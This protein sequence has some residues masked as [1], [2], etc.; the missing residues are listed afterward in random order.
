M[1]VCACGCGTLI[2]SDKR[3][4]KG[5]NR[6]L[7]G[8]EYLEQDC[9]YETPCWVWQRGLMPRGYGVYRDASPGSRLAHRRYYERFVGPI[10]E[11]LQLDHLCRN[12]ACVNPAH[13]EPVTN[14][15]NSQRGS[16]SRLTPSLVV[17]I[18]ELVQ[19]CPEMTR[20]AVGSVFN[21][22]PTTVSRVVM[23]RTWRNV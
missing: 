21:V 10:P 23:K 9:G 5:H 4:S 2:A 8:P 20:V 7:L 13:L 12:R 1:N 14:A 18:R 22:D 11:G 17:Q 6:R 15:V 19:R 16:K 3:F